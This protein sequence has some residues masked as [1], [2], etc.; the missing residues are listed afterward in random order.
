[1]LRHRKVTQHNFKRR[2][3]PVNHL[4]YQVCRS[5]S[6]FALHARYAKLAQLGLKSCQHEGLIVDYQYIGGSN[7]NFC[8]FDSCLGGLSHWTPHLHLVIVDTLSRSRIFDSG[9]QPSCR[10]FKTGERHLRV[11]L[12]LMRRLEALSFRPVAS[13]RSCLV[14]R[15]DAQLD[16]AIIVPEVWLSSA[17]LY[18]LL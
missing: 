6:A 10:V 4:L 9:K 5:D 3:S 14:R 15:V 8:T 11:E 17:R 12:W 13:H 2:F 16:L 18:L 7:V 1:M